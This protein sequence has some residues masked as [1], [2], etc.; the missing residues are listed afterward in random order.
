MKNVTFAS[1]ILLACLLFL[2]GLAPLTNA[3][4]TYTYTGNPF[5][6]FQGSYA[7]PPQCSISGSFTVPGPPP[8]NLSGI[9]VQ[10]QFNVTLVAYSFTDGNVTATNANSCPD[11]FTISTDG[12]GNITSWVIRLFTPSLNSPCASGGLLTGV[13]IL[14]EN[15]AT[16][17]IDIT[18]E[19]PAAVNFAAIPQD[20]GTW[21]M[22]VVPVD[23]T[24]PAL[25]VSAR[26]SRL[27]PPNGKMVSVT[28]SG[29][30]TDSSSGVDPTTATF[31]VADEYGSVQPTG[32]VSLGPGGSYLF[33]I[34]LEAS[35]LGGDKN[36]RQYT[37]TVSAEDLA[38]NP[39]S[40]STVVTVPHDEGNREIESLSAQ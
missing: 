17:I 23:T 15:D 31:S 6:I 2:L 20:P 14:S 24:P 30:I 22:Q 33:T 11:F 26:P 40:A 39:G 36:G 5:T 19:A 3:D 12:F 7:C 16:G 28:V 8:V 29:M 35:R 21:S 32:P 9:P 13:Q 37:I 1:G 10:N 34:L 25:N 4:T 38:G 18:I 27:W